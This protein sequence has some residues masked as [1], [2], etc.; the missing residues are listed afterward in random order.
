MHKSSSLVPLA[1]F[2][3]GWMDHNLRLRIKP[4]DTMSL[5]CLIDLCIDSK[6]FQG[7][8]QAKQKCRP[9]FILWLRKYRRSEEKLCS[10][11]KT[12]HPPKQL[13]QLWRH[14]S[15]L[16]HLTKT[17]NYSTSSRRPET[18]VLFFFV[19]QQQQKSPET[20]AWFVV[21]VRL[22]AALVLW[23]CV[24]QEHSRGADWSSDRER[25]TATDCSHTTGRRAVLDTLPISLLNQQV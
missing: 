24:R 9:T 4:I 10:V 11:L 1:A 3:W 6:S 21:G 5:W 25:P 7:W 2:V 17:R 12:S 19:E 23:V 13:R 8:T 16:Q 15:R 18:P 22:D 14:L 20:D